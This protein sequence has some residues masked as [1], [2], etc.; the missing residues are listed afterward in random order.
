M[1]NWQVL[2]KEI[3][4]WAIKIAVVLG[5]IWAIYWVINQGRPVFDQGTKYGITGR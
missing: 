3:I 2:I 4:L 1:N 5:I